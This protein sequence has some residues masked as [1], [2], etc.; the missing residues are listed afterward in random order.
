MDCPGDC[1][2]EH[3]STRA[4]TAC[5]ALDLQCTAF[6][7][8]PVA[9]GVG[10]WVPDRIRDLV[11]RRSAGPGGSR[12]AALRDVAGG[13]RVHFVAGAGVRDVVAEYPV[14]PGTLLRVVVSRDE[15]CAE[16]G[17][18]GRDGTETFRGVCDHRGVFACECVR[19]PVV[20]YGE[21]GGDAGVGSDTETTA[22]ESATGLTPPPYPLRG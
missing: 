11:G 6:M 15:Q 8:A 9:G 3:G 22:G 17:L 13:S 12:L 20:E 10:G 4:S 5:A 14:I 21:G 18:H 2:V 16:Y 1:V 7:P 19:Q